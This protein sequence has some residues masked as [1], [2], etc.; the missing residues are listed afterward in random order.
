M[1]YNVDFSVIIPHRDSLHF[2]PK[3]FST[4][5]DSEKIEVLLIDNSLIPITKED[6]K[7]SRNFI[8]LFSEPNRGAGGARNVGIKNAH[9]KW[10]I[11]IDA[12]DYLPND[13]FDIFYSEYD[14]DAEVIYF[15]MNGI[16]LDTGEY[17]DRG[18]KYTYLTQG[19]IN[20]K[21]EE[22]DIRV[23]FSS[24]CSK[25]IS[26]ELVNR[27]NIQFDE[28]IVSN[29]LYFSMLVGFYAKKIKAVDKVTYIATV[30][31]GSL[32][33]RRDCEA[34]K[35]RFEV[36]LRR[37]HFLKKHNLGKYQSSVMYFLCNSVLSPE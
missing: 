23:N 16:Y 15:C 36:R 24:P 10:L 28:V 6:V 25:M 30:S 19:Y 17:S 13:A 18:E 20:G 11:F 31:R 9:G 26:H 14:A 35:S 4:I 3:L 21:I 12:D 29:D 2:L 32:T 27:H 7:T 22:N 5:P 1:S 37:N 8:L 34:L 33:K